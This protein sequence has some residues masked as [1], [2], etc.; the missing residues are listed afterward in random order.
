MTSSPPFS[1]PRTKLSAFSLESLF[2]SQLLTRQ[3]SATDTPYSSERTLRQQH[4]NSSLPGYSPLYERS[5]TDLSTRKSI[6]TL[7]SSSST[8][9]NIEKLKKGW[10][11]MRRKPVPGSFQGSVRRHPAAEVEPTRIKRGVWKDQLLIDRSLRGMAALTALFALGIFIIIAA[12]IQPFAN[13]ANMYTSSIGGK[14]RSCKDVTMTNTALLL[15]INAAATMILGMSNTY[16]QLVTS[17]TIGD[18]KNMLQKFGDSK[19]GTNSPF[20]INHKKEG[21]RKSWLAWLLLITT[22]LPVHFLANSLIG[23]S[24][25]LEPPAIIQY[26]ETNYADMMTHGGVSNYGAVPVAHIYETTS[27]VCWSAFRTGKAHF[28]KSSYALMIDESDYG[29]SSNRLGTAY[30]TMIIQYSTE[31]CT[32]LV[33]STNDADM[34]ED[35]LK[36]TKSSTYPVYFNGNCRMGNEVRCSLYDMTPAK[37]RLNVRMNAA[38]VLL[39]C[40]T[41]K[42]IYMIVVNLLARGK[43]KTHCL[44]FGDV[45]VASSSDPELRVQGYVLGLRILFSPLTA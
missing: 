23:P 5:N 1:S 6:D 3:N 25:I 26:N 12:H 24:T 29:G 32:G 17:L 9:S 40:L 36:Y 15:L 31:N 20:N 27:F 28:P 45:L 18:L 37:C 7:A 35:E 11:R 38:F 2:P 42:A 30:S 34:I 44:T 8:G 43:L 41:I 14:T 33:N 19:V 16:Q 22:S 10:N 39:A 4:S 13:R 21:K